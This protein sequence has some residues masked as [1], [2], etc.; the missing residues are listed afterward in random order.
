MEW[1]TKITVFFSSLEQAQQILLELA[2]GL[3]VDRGERL[4]HQ[5][6]LGVDRERAGEPD[7]LAHAAGQLVRDSCARTGEADLGDVLACDRLAL[8]VLDAAQLEPEGDVA[9]D[10]RPGQQREVLEHE[11]PA[12]DRARYR[13]AADQDLAPSRA[14]SGRR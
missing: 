2:P 7:P 13:D 10:R 12:R 4:V 5:Q 6:D 11:A 3:L 14:R 1:V 9:Q 8:G